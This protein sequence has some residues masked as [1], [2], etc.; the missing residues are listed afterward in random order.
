MT[1]GE[2][3]LTEEVQ[4]RTFFV[5]GDIESIINLASEPLR[6]GKGTVPVKITQYYLTAFFQKFIRA[7]I[8]GRVVRDEVLLN[9]PLSK[10]EVE[11]L[12]EATLAE[13]VR[14]LNLSSSSLFEKIEEDKYT[15]IPGPYRAN[16]S[17]MEI[18]KIRETTERLQETVSCIHR[19]SIM[20]ASRLVILA[21]KNIGLEAEGV[22]SFYTQ[23]GPNIRDWE[24][25]DCE[26]DLDEEELD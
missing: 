23:G 2:G 21:A 8:T 12:I 6:N 7:L 15:F 26:E 19:A 4:L 9:F 24:D 13:V 20:E 25:E 16:I 3:F 17:L 22:N 11:N 1:I 14:T 18:E 10:I 5:K